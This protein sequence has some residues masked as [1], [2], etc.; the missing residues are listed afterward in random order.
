MNQYNKIPPSLIESDNGLNLLTPNIYFVASGLNS[1]L[2]YGFLLL[3][4]YRCELIKAL[5]CIV[6]HHFQP[7]SGEEEEKKP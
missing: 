3:H 7:K 2:A 5:L 4:S 6:H 1:L